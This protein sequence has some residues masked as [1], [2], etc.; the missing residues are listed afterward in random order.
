MKIIARAVGRRKEAVAQIQLITGTGQFIINNKSAQIYLQ[1]NSCSLIS[2]KSPFILCELISNSNLI[3]SLNDSNG[4]N[5]VGLERSSGVVAPEGNKSLRGEAPGSQELRSLDSTSI[6][7][8]IGADTNSVETNYKRD[9]DSSNSNSLAKSDNLISISTNQA[10]LERSS[11]ETFTARTE[12]GFSAART[13][14]DKSDLGQYSSNFLNFNFENIDTIVK[15]KGGGLIGQTE[16]IKLGVARALCNIKDFNKVKVVSQKTVGTEFDP[17]SVREPFMLNTAISSETIS[18]S[19]AQN[20]KKAYDANTNV[21]EEESIVIN[22]SSLDNSSLTTQT[23]SSPGGQSE[24]RPKS[25]AFGSQELRPKREAL[26]SQELRSLDSDDPYSVSTAT[27]TI[28]LDTTFN[29]DIESVFKKQLKTKGYLTQDSRVKE[30][31]KYGLKK[32]RKASQ[33][34]KR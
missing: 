31:R 27:N 18:T 24:L 30:R 5:G 8:D 22:Q 32:A 23:D 3:S 9:L 11:D 15:V 14:R 10:G 25:F 7:P 34:H 6:L 19:V 1:N 21:L 26:G 17:N 4:P 20:S 13:L 33:Y 16:A 2:V 12:F 28:L 29:R